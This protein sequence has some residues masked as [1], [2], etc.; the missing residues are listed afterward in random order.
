MKALIFFCIVPAL[1]SALALTPSN[2][3]TPDPASIEVP[4]KSPTQEV[5]LGSIPEP[6]FALLGG[7]GLLV[8]LR[9]RSRK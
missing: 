5:E 1:A 4:A 7:M 8:L 6:G 3:E 9:R 2:S